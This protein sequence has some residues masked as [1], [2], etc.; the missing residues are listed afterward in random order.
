MGGK[1]ALVLCRGGITGFAYEVGCLNALDKLFA[2]GFTCSEFDMCVGTSAGSI[3]AAIVSNGIDLQELYRSITD[4]ETSPM[5]FKRSDI[6]RTEP[7]AWKEGLKGML[8]E[9]VPVWR[10]HREKR[11]TMS[12]NDILNIVQEQFH[13]GVYSLDALQGYLQ[14]LFEQFGVGDRFDSLKNELFI[15]AADLDRGHRVIFGAEGYDTCRISEAITASC[16]IPVFFRPYWIEDRPYIDGAVI[17]P[18]HI[19]IAIDNGAT[20]IIL[21]NPLVPLDKDADGTILPAV[22]SGMPADSIAE[23]GIS[24]VREQ[25]ER[26][27]SHEKVM[28]SLQMVKQLYPEIDVMVLEPRPD[29]AMLF[30]HNPMSF[31][32]R[33]H[34]MTS[35]YKLVLRDL[36][37]NFAR[38]KAVLG[39]HGIRVRPD[40][41]ERAY[42]SEA[43]NEDD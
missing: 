22:S 12:T 31:E 36:A 17:N 26:I 40:F 15:T 34:V 32:L 35:A 21:I 13:S 30:L 37:E 14:A 3:A 6:Y 10:T 43:R 23:L 7:G 8:R 20:L 4:D 33:R 25:S 38:W 18:A 9:L 28:Q 19:D 29:D 24:Y 41:I 1:T 27:D 16:A 2:G 42:E 39:R 11:W 5:N